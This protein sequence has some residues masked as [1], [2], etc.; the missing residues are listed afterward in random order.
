M[1]VVKERILGAVTVMSEEDAVKIWEFI[2][3]KFGFIMDNPTEEETAIINAYEE[4]QD[5]YQPYITHE[6]LKKELEL[7]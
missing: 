3:I 2:K 4:N 6:D 7:E 5:D 1:S